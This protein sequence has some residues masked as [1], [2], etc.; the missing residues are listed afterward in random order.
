MIVIPASVPGLEGG[1]RKEAQNAACRSGRRPD[2]LGGVGSGAFETG[3]DG[4]TVLTTRTWRPTP[5][6]DECAACP[7]VVHE[8]RFRW[9]A[10]GF[11]RVE[12]RVVPSPYTAFVDLIQALAAGDQD[13]ALR[14]VTRPG[15]VGAAQ[16]A[17]WATAKAPWRS[18]PGRAEREDRMVFYRGP[19]EAWK[20]GFERSPDGW[21]VDTFEVVPRDVE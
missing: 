8:R 21:L 11:R 16:A 2:S 18:A 14:R 10:E 17:G 15:L 3:G 13:A 12:D 1:L 5:R 7:H 4:G 19:S 6:F 9:E 20:V